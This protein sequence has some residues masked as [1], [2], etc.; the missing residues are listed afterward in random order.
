M[1]SKGKHSLDG[2]LARINRK[3]EVISE[4]QHRLARQRALL[5]EQATRLRLGAS[6]DAV[7]LALKEASAFDDVDRSRVQKWD[8]R[9]VGS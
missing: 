4:T 7:S 5:R 1:D 8:A 2:L 9:L 6:P 3:L